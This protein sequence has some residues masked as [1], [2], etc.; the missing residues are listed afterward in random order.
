[1][2]QFGSK[3]VSLSNLTLKKKKSVCVNPA[4]L[5][6]WSQQDLNNSQFS[7]MM[8]EFICTMIPGLSCV[9]GKEK[10]NCQIHYDW[11]VAVL[12]VSDFPPSLLVSAP[13]V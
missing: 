5:L 9:E 2:C 6:K 3:Y 7:D 8:L 1:M 12:N 11:N 4:H 13:P 10:I